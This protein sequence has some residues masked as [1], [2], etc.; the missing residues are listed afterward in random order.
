MRYN[1][2]VIKKNSFAWQLH[3]AGQVRQTA[4]KEGFHYA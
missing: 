3:R 2:P 1:E 4:K